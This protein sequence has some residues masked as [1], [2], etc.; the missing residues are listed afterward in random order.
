MSAFVAWFKQV[1]F[2]KRCMLCDRILADRELDMCPEC[3]LT[4][5][6]ILNNAWKI[7]HVKNWIPL[8]RYAGYVRDSLI[9]YK[10]H[11]R[12]CYGPIYGREL[13]Q[14]LH[15]VHLHARPEAY[16]LVAVR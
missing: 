16:E 13:A 12:R 1:F 11:H 10:F 9:R 14:K 5:M 7:P 6:V 8:W 15:A 3:R 4:E 2:P